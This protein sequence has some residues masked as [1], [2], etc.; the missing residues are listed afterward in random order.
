M[1]FA[2]EGL[3]DHLFSEGGR[4]L[5][6]LPFGIVGL[7]EDNEVIEYNGAEEE[8]A[9]LT[10]EKVAGKDF[11]F[12]VAPCMNNFMVAERL[13]DEDEIDA[14]IDYVLTLRVKPTKV[15]IRLM[16]RAGQ[17]RRFIAIKRLV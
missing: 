3:P 10:R 7:N 5:D 4:D 9:G 15:R 13:N 6:E 11:F 1:N 2:E 16:K 17:D 14:I 8:I 12:E